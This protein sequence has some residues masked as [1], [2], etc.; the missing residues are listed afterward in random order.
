MSEFSSYVRSESDGPRL[1]LYLED[2]TIIDHWEAGKIEDHLHRLM[3]EAPAE[4]VDFVLRGVEV[5]SSRLLS[6]MV[7][8][9]QSGIA[10]RLIN[11][12]E[13]LRHSLKI[14]M[15]DA[16]IEVVMDGTA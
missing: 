12:S 6:L 2:R 14:T 1:V 8:L 16:M 11:P 4:G 3:Q 10:V 5:L 13:H 9:R 15:L 7:R